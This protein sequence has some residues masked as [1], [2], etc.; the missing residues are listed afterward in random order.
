[1]VNEPP[2]MSRVKSIAFYCGMFAGFMTLGTSLIALM[3][4]PCL[5]FAF[6]GTNLAKGVQIVLA[7]VSWLA[8]VFIGWFVFWRCRQKWAVLF[9]RGLARWYE[10]IAH[11]K[12]PN[13]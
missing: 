5:V 6:C 8:S 3:A 11:E 1:M 13:N 10:F 2:R 4:S 12:L 9:S 7:P